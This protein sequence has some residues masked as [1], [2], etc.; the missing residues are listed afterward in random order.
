MKLA[1]RLNKLQ[2]YMAFI[3]FNKEKCFNSQIKKLLTTTN[4]KNKQTDNRN[5]NPNIITI[6]CTIKI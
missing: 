5:S 1:L 4:Y 6:H 3:I 2:F